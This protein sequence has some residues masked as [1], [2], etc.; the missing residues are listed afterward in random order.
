MYRRAEISK[1]SEFSENCQIENS[2]KVKE[3]TI[4]QLSES[5]VAKHNYA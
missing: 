4:F 2:G 3:N 5:V 1:I